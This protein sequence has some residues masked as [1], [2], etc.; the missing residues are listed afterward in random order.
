M[1]ALVSL[2]VSAPAHAQLTGQDCSTPGLAIPDN[3][4]IGATDSLFVP[5]NG[6]ILDLDVYVN[7]THTWVGDL[8]VTL[9][10]VNTGTTETLIMRP[11]D[12]ALSCNAVGC[13]GCGS[14]D[15]DATLDD[16][17]GSLVENECGGP[18]PSIFG[19]FI[20]NN[21]L[22]AFDGENL[23]GAWELTVS[24]NA[25]VSLGTF[26]E[27]CLNWTVSDPSEL[28]GDECGGLNLGFESG[29]F[30]GWSTFDLAGSFPLTVTTAMGPFMPTD[31]MFA[32]IH[33]FNGNG[34]GVIRVFQDMALPPGTST[35]E[36]DY[37]ANWD[38]TCCG[39]T[40]DRTFTVHIEPA[41]GGA[42]LQSDLVLTAPAGDTTFDTGELVGIIDVSA[43]A[44]STVQVAFEWD[45]P[46]SL[47]GPA[48]FL[49]DDIRCSGEDCNGNGTDDR[50]DIGSGAS[51]DCDDNAI[52]DECEPDADGDGVTDGCDDCPDDPAK[53]DAGVCGCGTSDDDSDGDGAPDCF[54]DCP[55]DASKLE[56]G[57][58]GCGQADS[59]DD[60]DDDDVIDCLDNCPA[61]ANPDQADADGNGV[62]DICEPGAAGQPAGACGCGAGSALLMPLMLTAVGW[63]RRRRPVGRRR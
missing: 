31:G 45:V 44:G 7:I 5:T 54:D 33:G 13:C 58:C 25:L 60:A 22:S 21:P 41:G 39:A 49:L 24:D 52:P 53:V 32:A 1:L 55:G 12:A 30:T 11:G 50:D 42:P 51:E 6:T 15:I 57:F 27:W 59:L 14:N 61:V 10:H 46:E 36:F 63:M 4:A 62:G 20:P 29:D 40:L 23:S 26:V 34:P 8:C 38:L 48:L 19:T 16:E 47:P 37:R 56:A 2:L 43:F 17:A 9:R 35:L 18:P 3:D 28:I